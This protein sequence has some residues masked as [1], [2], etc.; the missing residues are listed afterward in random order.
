MPAWE[1]DMR[2]ERQANESADVTFL[3]SSALSCIGPGSGGRTAHTGLKWDPSE[4]VCI[5]L[6]WCEEDSTECSSSMT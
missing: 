6:P 5:P 2:Q 4:E 1:D 3:N